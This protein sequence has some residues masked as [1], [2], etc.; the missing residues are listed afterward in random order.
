MEGNHT[1]L[2]LFHRQTTRNGEKTAISDPVAARSL[3]YSE[4]DTYAGRIASKMLGKGV[5]RGDCVALIL[6]NGIEE[7]AA[8]LATMKLGAVFTALNGLYPQDRLQYICRDCKAKLAVRADFFE[9][10]DQYAPLPAE[11]PRSGDDIAMLVYT[12]GSTGTPKGVVIDQ[13]ALTASIHD[14]VTE[15]DVFGLGAPFFFVAGIKS[16][17]NGLACGCMNVLIPLSAMR[18]PEMLADFLWKNRVTVTFISPRV[19]RLFHPKGDSLRKVMTGSERL[20]R[21]WSDSF[22]IINTYGQSESIAG[23]LFFPVDHSYDNTPVG[24]PEDDIR[25]YLL[26]EKGQ[27]APEG[28]ICLTGHFARGYLN[29]PEETAKTFIPN[30]FKDRDGFDILL[31]T[32]DLGKRLPDGN[33]LFVNRKDWMIKINGQRVEPGEIEAVLNAVPGVSSCAVKDFT[34]RYGTTYLCAFYVAVPGEKVSERALRE[35]VEAKLP[36]YM[37]PAFYVRMD[38][39][40]VN[41]NGKLDRSA[42]EPPKMEMFQEKYYVA[43]SDETEERLCTAMAK[44]LGLERAGVH[45]DFFRLGGDSLSTA[46]MISESGLP[47]LKATQVFRGRTAAKIAKIYRAAGREK[48]LKEPDKQNSRALKKEHPLTAEQLYMI[49]YQLYTPNSTMYNLFVM[50]KVDKN[51]YQMKRLAS[52]FSKAIQN[53]PS[54]LTTFYYNDENQLV[55][56]YTPQTFEE[57]RVEYLTEFEL[58]F[59]RDTLVYPFQIIGGRLCRYRVF[60]TEKAG[61]LF[62]DVHHTVFDGFSFRVFLRS[63][64]SA[65][66]GKPLQKDYYY[67]ML[68]HREDDIRTDFYQASKKYFEERYEGIAWDSYPRIDLNAR[69]N[70]TGELCASFGI[71]QPQLQAAERAYRVSENEFFITV[72]LLAI[73]FYNGKQDIRVSWIYN[74]QIGRAHV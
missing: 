54:L 42:F 23:V 69:G 61:Y 58:K 46:A 47:E 53:H 66:H 14:T 32:G 17:L 56:R 71:L 49:D 12:S 36:P 11:Y 50:L 3:T 13:Y 21:T 16:L 74:G 33:I 45:D 51:E 52:A 4:L 55:Q 29:L 8:V 38:K 57:V 6:P 65:Y 5:C 2:D 39:L 28:E 59:V 24:K 19:L 48:E 31:R 34:N 20:S 37:H 62:F 9:D 43:P 41:A 35:Q 40:P 68:S 64:L 22:Q 26:N 7:A 10:V 30:P 63:V 70:E 72:A 60:E 15:K 18:D 73:A 67:L 25:V 1:Y 44:V 27:E